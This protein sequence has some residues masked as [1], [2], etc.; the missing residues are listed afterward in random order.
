MRTIAIDVNKWGKWR[1][2]AAI[3]GAALALLLGACSASSPPETSSESSVRV[4]VETPIVETTASAAVEIYSLDLREAAPGAQLEIDTSG[5]LV[6][7]TYRD[8]D[9][10]LVVELPNS[11]PA[12]GVNDLFVDDGLVE[13]VTVATEDSDDRPL[14]RLVVRTRAEAEHSVEADGT[15]LLVGIT[16]V[17]DEWRIAEVD[18]FEG[19]TAAVEET[20][21][22]EETISIAEEAAVAGAVSSAP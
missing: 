4:G 17:D 5:S 18:E 3:G 16:P 2:W 19:D 22:A 6:W 1:C 10:H 7:T 21:V 8:G 13:S 12:V 11:L 14:T 20:V 9:D 15:R